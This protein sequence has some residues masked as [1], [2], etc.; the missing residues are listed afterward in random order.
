MPDP[1]TWYNLSRTVQ[2]VQSILEAV[3]AKLLSHNQDPSAHGQ[4]GEVVQTHRVANILDHLDGS[5]NLKKLAKDNIFMMTCFESSDGWSTSGTVSF[6]IL[7]ARIET[8]ATTDAAAYAL[9]ETTGTFLTVDPSKNPFF[10]TTVKFLSNTAQN[11]Y[12]VMGAEPFE[13][14]DDSF[15]FKIVNSILYAYWTNGGNENTQELSG[16]AVNETHVY[17][18]YIDSTEEEIYFYVDGTL[19]YTAT[20]NFPTDTND[21]IFEYF[22]ET[23][24]DVAKIMKMAD[25]MIEIDR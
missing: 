14:Y 4:S 16:I 25:L 8:A 6:F 12:I 22:I 2:D 13:D 18:A 23:T 11:A 9:I 17:R 1:I 20:T 3:D 10:Q 15:G 21:W 24:E 19:E 7:E 5:I